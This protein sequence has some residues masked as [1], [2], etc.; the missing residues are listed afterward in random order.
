MSRSLG[1][2]ERGNRR[3]VAT[4]G[5]R[6]NDSISNRVATL[7]S[8]SGYKSVVTQSNLHKDIGIWFLTVTPPHALNA[9]LPTHHAN[10]T[11]HG[12]FPRPLLVTGAAGNLGRRVVE[13]LLEAKAGPI[14]ATTR[15]PEKLADFAKRGVEVRKADF[16]DPKTL[17]AAFAG[18]ERLLLISTGDLFPDGARLRQHRAA[19]EAA[20]DAKVKHVIYTSA[21]SPYPTPARLADQ[22]PLLDRA[23]ALREP[24]RVDDPA[25]S[26]VHRVPARH[27]EHR[28][29][30]R[31][32]HDVRRQG[33]RELRD[34]R[35]LRAHRR[36]RARRPTSAADGFST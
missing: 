30:V 4:T 6:P 31:A 8:Q 3:C 18:A 2:E 23:G 17:K 9:G 27:A 19:V 22:R 35:G 1:E 5:R 36:G 26:P 12:Q 10:E 16:N 32:A 28:A 29:E 24:A 15:A 20:V 13:L 11:R 14:I 33:R 34:A 21:P 7:R 25:P